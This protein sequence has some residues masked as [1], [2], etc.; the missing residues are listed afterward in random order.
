M[1]INHFHNVIDNA[2]PMQGGFGHQ[3]PLPP[4]P[5]PQPQPAPFFGS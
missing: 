5:Q 4:M 3:Q 2:F 1:D